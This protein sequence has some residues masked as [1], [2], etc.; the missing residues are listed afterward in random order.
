M[1]V[2]RISLLVSG[3]RPARFSRVLTL[4][5]AALIGGMPLY[6]GAYDQTGKACWYGPRL[7]GRV[8]ASGQ[9]FNQNKLTA[10]HPELPFGTRALVTNLDNNKAVRVT[11]NDRGPH[12]GG[13][14]IDVSRAAAKRL[15]MTESGI[16]RVR[17][18]AAS[19]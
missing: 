4:G 12:V 9:I 13:C 19:R 17:I 7:H 15:G 11:I 1:N 8:T 6:A 18:Q 2:R 10:A 14:V 16:S 3:R 5:F